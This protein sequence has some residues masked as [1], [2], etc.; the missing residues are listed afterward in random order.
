[1]IGQLRRLLIRA[2]RSAARR[3]DDERLREELEDHLAQQADDYRRTGVGHDDAHRL[4]IVKFGS[5]ESMK[6][7]WRDEQR[8]P[9]IEQLLQDTRIALRRMRQAPGFTMAAVATL[10]LGLGIGSA[11]VSLANAL[12]LKPLPVDDAARVVIVDQTIPDRPLSNGYPHAFP[13]YL[14]YRKHSRTLADLAAHYSTSPM[15]IVTPDGAFNVSGAVVTANYFSLLR[16]QPAAGRFFSAEEDRVPG[17]HPLAVLS[18]D[19]WRTKFG[20]DARAI[21][22]GVRVNGTTFTVIGVMPNGFRGTV[23]GVTPNDVWIPTAM[24]GI[25]YRYCDGLAR[26]C[27]VVS[28][29]GR[30]AGGASIPDAQAEIDVLASQL[31]TAFPNT[32]RNRGA[33]VRAARGIRIENQAREAPIVSLLAGGAALVLLVASANVAGLLLARGLRRRREIVIRRALG[34]TRGRVVRLLLVE[35]FVLALAGGAAGFIVAI[36]T[37][38]LLRG[39]FGVSYVGGALNIDFGLDARVVLF[40][41]GVAALTGIATGIAPALQATRADALP[42][43]KDETPGAGGRQSRLREGLIVVQVAISVMLLAGSGLLV[44]SFLM[45]HRGP[46]FDPDA[47]VLLRLRPSLVGYAN[48]R[49]WA[50]QHEVIRRLEVLPGVVAASPAGTP[51]LPGWTRQT[52]I[53]HPAASGA[54]AG[55]LRSGMTYV[56]ARYFKTLG[57]GV[58]E[59]REFDDSD[60]S[61]GARVVIVNE[62]LARRLWPDGRAVGSR[63]VV[64]GEP[65]DVIGVVRDLQFLNALEPPQPAVYLNFWQQNRTD[66][67][68]SDVQ[69]HVRISGPASALLAEIPRTIAAIDPDVPVS[70]T[71]T[72]GDRIDYQFSQVRLAR[73]LLLGFGGL[74]FVLSTI[75]LYAALAFLVGQRQRE[76]A[77]RLA[78]G[79][80]H[81][82]VAAL[83]FRRGST[84]V[85]IGLAVG[86]AAAL[87]GAGPLLANLLYGVSPRDPLALLAGPL[88]LGMVAAAAIWFPA[89]RAMTMDAVDVL[90]SE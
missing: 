3:Q 54:D 20:Q 36:W 39:F 13:D 50:F 71:R 11:V 49:A 14:Y 72:L 42:A 24:F 26:G 8:V 59:G 40:G 16:L 57:T 38:D 74:A 62:T 88:V 44:R 33:L 7:A 87:F 41:V 83:V 43:L 46:G 53:T 63:L 51:P 19:L 1:V 70:E 35:S 32:N 48:E 82:H 29:L 31:A 80:T 6:E 18:Y 27:N 10:A 34:A 81:S 78:L 52:E 47:V 76:L 77:I 30:L 67:W 45:V 84:I 28:L 5:V 60:G 56:G 75:G 69:L 85:G 2:T 12:F 17:A 86:L 4:A 25:G 15:Q 9:W 89:R 66:N 21:G 22:A 68:S 61:D 64:S 58:L 73:A 65:R 79:A 90:R 55:T 37:M 23:G